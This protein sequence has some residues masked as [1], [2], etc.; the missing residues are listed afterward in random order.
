V[1]W[2]ILV[3]ALIVA[4]VLEP[5]ADGEEEPLMVV[6]VLCSEVAVGV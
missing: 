3:G 2:R 4:V 6:A 5:P 1:S